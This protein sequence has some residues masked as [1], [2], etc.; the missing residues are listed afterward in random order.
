M[1]SVYWL[2][3]KELNVQKNGLECHPLPIP[4]I[5][6]ERTENM[7]NIVKY[8]IS[9]IY[10]KWYIWYEWNM[11]AIKNN[12]NWP[13]ILSGFMC[14]SWC[15]L[16]CWREASS[17]ISFSSSPPAGGSRRSGGCSVT[18]PCKKESSGLM[19]FACDANK[20]TKMM[21]IRGMTKKSANSNIFKLLV[22]MKGLGHHVEYSFVWLHNFFRFF[23]TEN[24]DATSDWLKSSSIS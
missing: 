15:R 12:V 9:D 7:Q 24:E 1:L 13:S 16:G 5:V 3:L 17:T 21:H 19:V 8:D 18:T 22:T 2:W 20:Q 4:I 6:I 14:R 10:Y 23:W 11:K